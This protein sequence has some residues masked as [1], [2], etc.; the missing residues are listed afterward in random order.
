ML[1]EHELAPARPADA[2]L[3]ELA[4]LLFDL[5]LG[6]AV[7][8]EA[9]DRVLQ[10]VGYERE[11]GPPVTLGAGTRSSA[12]EWVGAGAEHEVVHRVDEAVVRV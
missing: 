6:A 7:Q 2:G 1:A 3:R 9:L 5:S 10:D 11:H 8:D 4:Q 12:R